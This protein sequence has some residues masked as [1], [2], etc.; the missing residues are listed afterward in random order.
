MLNVDHLTKRYGTVTAVD[1]LSFEV[2]PGRVTGF[3]GPNGAGKTTTLRMLV[4]L[5]APTSGTATIPARNV[6][7]GRWFL[8][9]AERG[10]SSTRLDSRHRDGAAWTT[11]N[12]VRPLLHGA[13]YFAELLAGIRAMRAGDL[14]LF[15]DWRGDPDQRLE[16]PGTE[17]SRVLAEAAS[18][19]VIVRGLLW[20]SHLD[21]F[22]YSLQ[23]HRDLGEAI[24]AA[25]GECL[26]DMRVRTR[27]SH[28]QKLVVLRHAGRPERDVAYV[29]GIDL[30]HGR[31]D[32]H[33]HRGDEQPCPLG[34]AYGPRP[35]WH[36]VQLAIQGPA[37]ADVETVFRE[38]WEDPTPLTRNP[39]H[40]W[41]DRAFRTIQPP[42]CPVP[43]PD[44][45]PSGTDAVQVLRTYPYRR[46]RGY[47]FAPSGERSIARAYRKALDRARYL[48]Y[49]E[50][51]Y[52]WSPHVVGVFAE[53]LAAHPG[54]R[55]IA[56]VPHH[57]VTSKNR[58]VT[59][60]AVA[61]ELLARARSLDLLRQLGGDR[62]GIY[63][64]ENHAGTPV[65][66]HAKV[67]IVDDTWATVGSG[68]VNRRSWTHDSELS[69]AVLGEAAGGEC[70]A[71]DLRLALA[72]EHLDRAEDDDADL[73]GPYDAFDAFAASASRLDAW[74]AE[75][76][77][78]PRPPGRLRRHHP[79]P[80][81]AATVRW[82]EPLYRILFDP[83]G[84]PPPMR[85]ARA[86]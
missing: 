32:D 60:S 65:Y 48:V 25:G 58:P 78:G 54:L 59:G 22:R 39:L 14:L 80:L 46:R 29:G 72:R 52:L 33:A 69:C 7:L 37:V 51:Q 75:G 36:D 23:E 49:L 21:R 24:V 82:A 44:P 63:D 41:R 43:L 45:Q 70:L 11:G 6:G 15:T 20:R 61:P 40:R 17:V 55:L 4:G 38:R 62:V 76:R 50:D 57:P 81:P 1:G 86:F 5:T 77:R 12:R 19:G 34:A 16:G 53:A 68:N 30:C 64:V 56:V 27:G 10:N 2:G 31:R 13:A 18:R 9:A 42:P 74:Y 28:H 26:L 67:C 71:Q 79:T 3:L 84:R 83:D 35:P 47:S 85:R 8:T 73:R 66:V